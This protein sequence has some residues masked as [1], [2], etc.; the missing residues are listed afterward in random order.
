MKITWSQIV[1]YSRGLASKEVALAVESSPEAMEKV[2]L[3][4][5]LP[6]GQEVEVPESFLNRAK[7]LLPQIPNPVRVWIGRLVFAGGQSQ[8]GF[9]SGAS[10]ARDLQFEFED[11]TLELR[12]EPIANSSRQSFVGQF[13]PVPGSPVQVIVGDVKGWC[14]DSGMFDL[15]APGSA[16]KLT[17]VISESGDRF[18]V[19]LP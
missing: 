5:L 13:E 9:R 14:D 6:L 3:L 4:K 2:N 18:E 7:A 8:P 17:L 19:E 10:S 1:D 12:I 15:Q 16:T 11:A